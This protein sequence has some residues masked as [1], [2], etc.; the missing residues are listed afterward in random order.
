MLRY[1]P[2]KERLTAPEM[3]NS[4]L[5]YKAA[6]R[7]D[8]T[9]MRL[10]LQG[11]RVGIADFKFCLIR[12]E[13]FRTTL[14][15][16]ITTCNQDVHEGREIG[17]KAF[18]GVALLVDHGANIMSPVFFRSNAIKQAVANNMID[19]ARYL[20]TTVSN[21]P[22]KTL[23][24]LIFSCESVEMLQM[25]ML[26][27]ADITSRADD[28]STILMKNNID[29]TRQRAIRILA[30]SCGV[31]VNAKCTGGTTALHEAA[32][33]GDLPSVIDLCKAG[34]SLDAKDHHGRIPL[35]TAIHW[36]NQQWRMRE[37][38]E[39]PQTSVYG[40]IR[41]IREEVSRRH[42]EALQLLSTVI[43]DP[44]RIGEGSTFSVLDRETQ[45][46]IMSMVHLFPQKKDLD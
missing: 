43:E 37:G 12:D 34:A 38:H 26:R 46:L 23:N 32:I 9:H 21:I 42:V 45:K 36:C 11:D 13:V 16:F 7:G 31:D 14:T 28:G 15:V 1:R 24:L 3:H 10:I 20:I 17:T 44:Y 6:E 18:E 41:F 22:T 2:N 33:Y 35:Q 27:G 39:P 19:V 8:L 30:L 29:E 4:E 40:T 5:L 25:L